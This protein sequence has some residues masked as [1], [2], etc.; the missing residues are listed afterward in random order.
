MF[1]RPSAPV[2]RVRP[3]RCRLHPWAGLVQAGAQARAL[4]LGPGG[5]RHPHRWRRASARAAWRRRPPAG[6]APTRLEQRAAQG[7]AGAELARGAG[8]LGG[9]A[10]ALAELREA[11]CPLAW[12]PKSALK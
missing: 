7:R 11:S 6:G 12:R 4:R 2:H 5:A 8:Q 9:L 3:G 1:A 10:R